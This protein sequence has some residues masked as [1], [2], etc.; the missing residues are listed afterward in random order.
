ME[1]GGKTV[2]ISDPQNATEY[3][4]TSLKGDNKYV[5]RLVATNPSGS[6]VG[7]VLGP[8]TTV[9]FAPDQQDKSGWMSEVPQLDG[10]K[11]LARRLSSRSKAKSVKYWYVIDGRL[12]SWFTDTNAK[13]EVGYLHL[14]KL[15]RIT[16]V[17]DADG[18]ARQFSLILKGGTTKISLECASSDPNITTHDYTL[19]WMGSIQKALTAQS[20]PSAGPKKEGRRAS[21]QPAQED[22]LLDDEPE[23]EDDEFGDDNWGDAGFDDE[24]GFGGFEDE[25]GG[26]GED[27]DE[28][29][30]FGGGGDDDFGTEGEV[31]FGGDGF[32]EEAEDDD[33]GG[34]E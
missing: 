29:D 15:K 21:I 4:I 5:F 28:D 19:S 13:E 2:S 14:S 7:N 32:D 12:L 3:T 17:P 26:F 18:Q 30:D 31:E 9:E 34:F 10:K 25:D 1:N 20:T 22:D 33:F 16:Y 23:E 6:S 11:T 8:V 27:E 24:G